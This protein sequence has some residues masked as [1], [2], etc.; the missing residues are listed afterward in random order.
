MY[1]NNLFKEMENFILG[2][3][4]DAEKIFANHPDF[5][6]AEKSYK[7][8]H[9]A[10]QELLSKSGEQELLNK[11]KNAQ[12]QHDCLLLQAMYLQALLDARSIFM[13]FKN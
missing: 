8:N 13:F 6:A 11:F 7:K 4:T 3:V 9:D 5:E 1:K 2:R 12:M 10:I